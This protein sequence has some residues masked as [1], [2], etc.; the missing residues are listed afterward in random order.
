M[1][2]G[3]CEYTKY[4]KLVLGEM[5]VKPDERSW[6]R[7]IECS[8]KN[9]KRVN[10]EEPDRNKSLCTLVVIARMEKSLAS[11]IMTECADIVKCRMYLKAISL[12]HC[13]S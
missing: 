6:N 4:F 7:W 11:R 3:D 12:K 10:N 1:D 9:M 2:G 5:G 8:K 13:A